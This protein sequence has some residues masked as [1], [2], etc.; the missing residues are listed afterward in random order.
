MKANSSKQ[1]QAKPFKNQQT[2]GKHAKARK[3]N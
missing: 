1:K 3:S 2:P